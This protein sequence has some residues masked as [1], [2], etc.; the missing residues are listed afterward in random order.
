MAKELQAHLMMHL[1]PIM[2]G[3]LGTHYLDQKYKI[4]LVRKVGNA[5]V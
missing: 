1:L 2:Q 5:V 4:Q 3:T